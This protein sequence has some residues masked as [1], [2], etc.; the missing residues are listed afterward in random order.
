MD[1]PVDRFHI[2]WMVF[3]F[4]IC[5]HA[6]LVLIDL[7]TDSGLVAFITLYPIYILTYKEACNQFV[8]TWQVIWWTLIL[9]MWGWIHYTVA[10]LLAWLFKTI[11]RTPSD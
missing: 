10:C 3:G 7:G 5:L 8:C 9:S 1:T 11:Q 2:K 6:F 4:L